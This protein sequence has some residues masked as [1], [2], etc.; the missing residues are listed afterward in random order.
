MIEQAAITEWFEH[1]PWASPSQVEQDLILSRIL[2]HLFSSSLLKEKLAF[3]GG[4]AL[5]KLFFNPPLRYSEDIDLVQLSAEPIGE[6]MNE[7]RELI[8]PWLGEPKWRLGQGR[9]TLIYRFISEEPEIPMRVKIEI[10]SREH[11]T[12]LGLIHIP[13]VVKNKWFTGKA[14][15]TTYQI[16]ELL[17][18]KLRA[19]YQR[20][21]GRDLFD[22]ERAL[23]LLNNI[24][25]KEIIR[26]FMDYMKQENLSVSR[27][28]FEKNMHEKIKN[29]DFL[30]DMHGLL[31]ADEGY[32][33]TQAYEL[34]HKEIIS[35]LLGDPWKG[36]KKPS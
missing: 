22:L 25:P 13:F 16:N 11:F 19:L 4:T 5:N 15:V 33:P 17:G 14:N 27:A 21:K 2:C 18:T 26:C 20:S 3:R 10:N 29:Y 34:V 32:N 12:L 24:S 7:L 35:K 1:A 8:D 28:E 6:V 9:V 30:N 23:T 31:K 36:L